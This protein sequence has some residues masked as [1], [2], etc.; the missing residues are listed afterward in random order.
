MRIALVLAVVLG[1]AGCKRTLHWKLIEDDLVSRISAKAPP[2]TTI[3]ATCPET[4]VA[5]GLTFRCHV[6]ASD[7]SEGD[8]EITLLDTSGGYEMKAVR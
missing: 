8:I 3:T 2:G 4:P 7:H 1:A 6:A 5:K